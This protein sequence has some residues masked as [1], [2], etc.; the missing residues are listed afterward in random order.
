MADTFTSPPGTPE[1][2]KVWM[3]FQI[4]TPESKFAK[5]RNHPLFEE[6]RQDNVAP[7]R[8]LALEA[9]IVTVA[10][11]IPLPPGILDY[12]KIRTRTPEWLED[13]RPERRR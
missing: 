2:E 1:G 6:W 8:K 5:D 10:D 12:G 3:K 7:E 11:R 9:M 4:H 13:R